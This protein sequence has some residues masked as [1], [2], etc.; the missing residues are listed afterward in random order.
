MMVGAM[1]EP[2]PAP[3]TNDQCPNC[4]LPLA[5][6]VTRATDDEI[7]AIIRAGLEAGDH[8]GRIRRRLREALAGRVL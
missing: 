7:D 8:S 4:C 5:A 6:I 3:R 1:T 2:T